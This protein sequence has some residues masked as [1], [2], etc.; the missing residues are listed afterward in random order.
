MQFCVHVSDLSEHTVMDGEGMNIS[1]IKKKIKILCLSQL[2]LF[3]LELPCNLP[4][5]HFSML[6][7]WK[8]VCSMTKVLEARDPSPNSSTLSLT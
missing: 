5:L 3:F 1:L 7:S 6:L 2:L 4:Q 8:S